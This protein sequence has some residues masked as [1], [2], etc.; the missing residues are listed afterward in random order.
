MTQK[1]NNYPSPDNFA[2][3]LLVAPVTSRKPGP[4][5]ASFSSF[6]CRWSGSLGPALASVLA[7]RWRLPGTG[8][9]SSL[10]PGGEEDGPVFCWCL[11]PCLC[12]DSLMPRR[13]ELL[14][15][16]KT[17]CV[18][19]GAKDSE[20]DNNYCQTSHGITLSRCWCCPSTSVTSLL[21]SLLSTRFAGF[22]LVF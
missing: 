8:P 17:L 22:K 9:G 20:V 21:T 1:Q 15:E 12:H 2:P 3:L 11:R 5:P 4:A 19:A 7:W 14:E 13:G 18:K 10:L 6:T 16:V